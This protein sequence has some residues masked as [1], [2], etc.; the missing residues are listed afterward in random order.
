MG[1]SNWRSKSAKKSLLV[2][3]L[4]ETHKTEQVKRSLKSENIDLALIPGGLISVLQPLDFCLNKPFKDRV[5]QRWMAWMVE[6]IYELTATGR[7]KKPSEELMCQWIGEGWRDIPQEMVAR[8]FLKCRITNA[9]DGSK[10]D[11]VFDSSSD[12][13]SIL[14]DEVLVDELFASDSELKNLYGF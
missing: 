5:R 2:L 13:D 7:Q 10:D 12:D 9:L 8:S 11:C 14:E 6:G 1:L 3:D 4:F